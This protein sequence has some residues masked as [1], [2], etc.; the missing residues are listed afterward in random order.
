MIEKLKNE[1][2]YII[3]IHAFRGEQIS[4]S[5]NHVTNNILSSDMINK[6]S[7][8]KERE[9]Y[10]YQFVKIINRFRTLK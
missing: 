8:G 9:W 7:I 1:T 3:K 5:Q 2:K 6:N 4:V 10:I